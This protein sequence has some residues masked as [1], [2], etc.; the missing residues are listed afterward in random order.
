[1]AR[2]ELSRRVA[3]IMNTQIIFDLTYEMRTD[4]IH[5]VEQV[6]TFDDLPKKYQKIIL[7]AEA[8]KA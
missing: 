5:A 2:P 7:A 6:D 8:E 1:M 4:L 3:K